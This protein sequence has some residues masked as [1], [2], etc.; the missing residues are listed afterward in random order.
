MGACD[1]W[2]EC[3]ALRTRIGHLEG[4]NR[5]V[6]HDLR[7]PL[8]TV[9]GGARLA[10]QALHQGNSPLATALLQGMA[11]RADALIA[12]LGQL[13]A[14]S[15]GPAQ[16]IENEA[17][18]LTQLAREAIAELQLP[19]RTLPRAVAIELQPLPCAHGAPRLLKQVFVNLLSNA[20]KFTREAAQPRI[21]IGCRGEAQAAP[22]IFVRDNGI[23]LPPG[24]AA[25]LF[26][27]FGRL[28]GAAYPGCGIG[29]SL[30]RQVVERHGGLVWAEAA[31][32]EGGALFC[33]TLAHCIAAE[34]ALPPQDASYAH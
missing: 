31:G 33:F 15:E 5:H 2:A 22:V 26:Q 13:L 21:V 3:A 8:A 28:H 24:A 32:P 11:E 34:H 12:L 14:L 9:A 10:A 4:F 20:L 23:G 7:D 6:A 18:D 27:P 25:R 16:P 19:P 17:V 30:V 29:L 1:G